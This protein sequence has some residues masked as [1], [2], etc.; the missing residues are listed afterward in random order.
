[1]HWCVHA[2]V[3]AMARCSAFGFVCVAAVIFVLLRCYYLRDSEPAFLPAG[4]VKQ[5][6]SDIVSHDSYSVQ[7]LLVS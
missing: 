2:C 6:L 7:I 3:L 1:M 4:S 5:T